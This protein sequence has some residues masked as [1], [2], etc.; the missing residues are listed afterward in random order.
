M[1]RN[2]NDRNRRGG[3]DNDARQIVE[4]MMEMAEE[5][6]M[7]LIDGKIKSKLSGV[8]EEVER[9]F[10]E[11]GFKNRQFDALMK[12][13]T[14]YCQYL[15]V[16]E[17]R[18]LTEDQVIEI[19]EGAICYLVIRN[20]WDRDFR[21]SRDADDAADTARDFED[22]V[23][24]L[25][26]D[27]ED[28]QDDH[29]RR[30]GG[31]SRGRDRGRSR[32]TRNDRDDGFRR[33]D[34]R[35][36]S[37]APR[38]SSRD[39][40][41]N[42]RGSKT[43]FAAS[44]SKKK[45]YTSHDEYG[46]EYLVGDEALGRSALINLSK[47][48]YQHAV[49]RGGMK[50]D[51]ET[52]P[53]W[54][55][56][57]R[58]QYFIHNG[59]EPVGEYADAIAAGNT[60][61]A[62]EVPVEEERRPAPA[63]REVKAGGR[64]ARLNNWRGRPGAGQS[65]PM[66]SQEINSARSEITEAR[67]TR[68]VEE[69]RP[70]KPSYEFVGD[71]VADVTYNN[72][73]DDPCKLPLMALEEYLA[74]GVDVTDT[75]FIMSRPM[76]V[77]EEFV[78]VIYDP[79]IVRQEWTINPLGHRQLSARA[80]DMNIDDHKIPTFGTSK[81]VV[82]RKARKDVVSMVANP[83]R[84]T[85]SDLH[86][87]ID[88]QV[89]DYAKLL[90]QWEDDNSGLPEDMRAPQPEEPGAVEVGN[91]VIS[92]GEVIEGASIEAI[93]DEAQ[94]RI[95]EMGD[96]ITKGNPVEVDGIVSRGLYAPVNNEEMADILE[97]LRV[98]T[99]ANTGVN[100]DKDTGVYSIADYW[101]ALNDAKAHIPESVFIWLN[102]KITKIVNEILF[103]ALGAEC[104][105]D[106]FYADVKDLIEGLTGISM[107]LA[108]AFYKVVA[109]EHTRFQIMAPGTGRK[110]NWI[111][112]Y[113]RVT[114]VIMPLCTADIGAS[115]EGEPNPNKFAVNRDMYPKLNHALTTMV[116]RATVADNVEVTGRY[117]MFADRVMYNI[118]KPYFSE[119]MVKHM[120]KSTYILVRK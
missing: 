113:A 63:S 116:K 19:A 70:A 46:Y 10:A 53:E 54:E 50:N 55:W 106:D 102:D 49:G 76:A 92:I 15:L 111:C 97:R 29:D 89:T 7:D 95:S 25:T 21:D 78:P 108:E 5:V 24:E 75:K 103:D 80:I 45:S 57:W 117:V 43:R 120:D 79:E 105:I 69:T 94:I 98:F 84:V 35:N 119:R 18:E 42:D 4:D 32:D 11:R 118:N 28:A 61:D 101:N 110:A 34:D 90:K 86:V 27:Y 107:D 77:Q 104:N 56:N 9:D 115:I 30:N 6:T 8:M 60:G 67:T 26:E 3:R 13:V 59:F 58:L 38:R 40:R 83:L 14:K 22:Y 17:G 64:D 36:A 33:R 16:V 48:A 96:K 114:V 52:R 88:D 93:I 62:P 72:E 65:R 37:Q 68:P 85:V 41:D 20:K 87:R 12:V 2:R 39:D 112:E 44:R 71:D 99:P 74:L 51:L 66:T 109:N 81:G 1:A 31:R 82:P 100:A 47:N 91:K 73:V 23:D